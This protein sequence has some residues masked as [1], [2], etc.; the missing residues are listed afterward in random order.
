M[1]AHVYKGNAHVP[2]EIFKWEPA[3]GTPMVSRPL[4]YTKNH[5]WQRR[6]S[7]IVCL[8]TLLKWMG[9]LSEPEALATHINKLHFQFLNT[10]YILK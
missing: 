3:P 9:V 8:Q 2:A 7:T 10:S 4:Y 6:F 5:L 1:C